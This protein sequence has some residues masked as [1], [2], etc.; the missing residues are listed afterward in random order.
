MEEDMLNIPIIDTGRIYYEPQNIMVQND[1]ATQL[2]TRWNYNDE[3]YIENEKL[4]KVINEM[5][6]FINKLD[7]DEEICSKVK[8]GTCEKYNN[9]NCEKCIIEYFER[10]VQNGN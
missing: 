6:K 7:A 10:E 1:V 2:F 4:K 9:G 8:L 5:A 3:Q